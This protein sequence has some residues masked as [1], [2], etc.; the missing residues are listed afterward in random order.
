MRQIHNV[1]VEKMNTYKRRSAPPS[2]LVLHFDCLRHHINLQRIDTFQLRLFWCFQGQYKGG[3][4]SQGTGLS[5]LPLNFETENGAVQMAFKQETAPFKSPSVWVISSFG[6]NSNS[7][8][9]MSGC[10]VASPQSRTTGILRLRNG[11]SWFLGTRVTVGLVHA[12]EEILLQAVNCASF[13][14]LGLELRNCAY[15]SVRL[16]IQVL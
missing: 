2:Y 1:A 10:Q 9:F 14:E 15:Q 8:S 11:E 12:F 4:G 6:S 3:C 5:Q 13:T 16:S 7:R